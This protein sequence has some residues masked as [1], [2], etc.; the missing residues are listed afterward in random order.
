MTDHKTQ[1]L[2]QGVTRR[3]FVAQ[4]TAGAAGAALAVSAS[5]DLLAAVVGEAP[6]AVPRI[7]A[8]A[9]YYPWYRHDG[10]NW[11][12][13]GRTPAL[14]LYDSNNLGVIDTHVTWALDAGLDFLLVAQSGEATARSTATLFSRSEKR[15]LQLGLMVTPGAETQRLADAH[16]RSTMPRQHYISAAATELRAQLEAV[17]RAPELR[18]PNALKDDNGRPVVAIRGWDTPQ[19]MVDIVAAAGMN[20]QRHVAL[21]T[22]P[23]LGK[24][25]SQVC[26]AGDSQVV[27]AS[28]AAASVSRAAQRARYVVVDSFNDWRRG[29]TLEP[30]VH[31]GRTV[32]ARV[33]T[34]R[35]ML[36]IA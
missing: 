34:L 15:A 5:S 21:W 22:I 11:D 1:S 25:E 32:T 16:A 10:T 14:G 18:L 30:S 23:E 3:M 29:S 35:T 17:V 19:T 13:R 31:E 24:N 7:R 2:S 26:A 20:V 4:V 9:L 33:A 8:G 6:A 36:G 12:R 27:L 28:A